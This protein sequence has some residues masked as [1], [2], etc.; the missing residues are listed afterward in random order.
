MNMKAVVFVVVIVAAALVIYFLPKNSTQETAAPAQNRSM[1]QAGS[2]QQHDHGPLPEVDSLKVAVQDS[3]GNELATLILVPH[4]TVALPGTEYSLHMTDFY[5]H[6]MMDDGGVV[7][8]SP[9]PENPAA[10]IEIYED[11]DMVDYTWTFQ[12]VPFFRM[13]G[14]GGDPHS[15]ATTGLAFAVLEIYG[16]QAPSSTPNAEG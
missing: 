2:E 16:L 4:Q 10:R 3:L 1:M 15:R 13:S 6:F 8:A 5:T 14:M 7:N 12:K 9:H 11:D